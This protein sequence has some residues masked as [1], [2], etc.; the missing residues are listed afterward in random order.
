MMMYQAFGWEPPVF[1]HLSILLG[2]DRSKLSKRHGDTALLEFRDN[3][4]LS[5]TMFNFLSLLGWSAG[6]AEEV[7][8]RCGGS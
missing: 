2:P 8:T 3:G 4:F 7:M 6:A 1:V 5:E